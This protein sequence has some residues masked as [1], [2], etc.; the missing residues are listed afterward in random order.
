M[1]RATYGACCRISNGTDEGVIMLFAREAPI[2]TLGD[3]C[4]STMVS[5]NHQLLLQ[6]LQRV[7]PELEFNHVLTRG[8]WY[9]PAGIIDNRGSHITHNLREWVEQQSGGD[10]EQL[11]EACGDK[12]YIVTISTGRTHYFV[13]K[14][15]EKARDFVQLEVEQ[16]QEVQDHLLF[17]ADGEL[18]D[19]IE[20]VIDPIDI[21]KLESVPVAAP[22]YVFRRITPIAEFT[23][24]M[25][26]YAQ[27]KADRRSDSLLRF[28]QD[29]DRSS[30]REAG[31]FCHH[32][33]LSLRSYTDAW[34][35]TNLQALPIT[36]YS[37]EVDH[38]SLECVD[39]GAG[40]AR[41]IH[42]FDRRIGYPMAWYFFML[43]HRQVP[44]Q[45]AEAIHRDQMGAYDYLPS[46]DLKILKEWSIKPY[47]I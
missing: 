6:K 38:M 15:G 12:N 11:Y 17:E 29:W 18:P 28:M 5:D 7:L 10:I 46:R 20:E 2:D 19:N 13:A 14:T 26:G 43:S 1:G 8:G 34:N 32:W 25:E 42:G 16:L 39:R 41:L 23:R 3:V 33:V 44:Y 21:D 47:G 4:A 9:R 27:D 35:E 22:R 40:L 36:T 30:A 37:E 31:P 24:D 45:L